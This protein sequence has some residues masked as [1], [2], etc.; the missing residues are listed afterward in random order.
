MVHHIVGTDVHLV[1]IV[2]HQRS[3]GPADAQE[4]SAGFLREV[5]G[6]FRTADLLAFDL[7][8]VARE[9]VLPLRQAR[10]GTACDQK[11]GE[12]REYEVFAV[13]CHKINTFPLLIDKNNI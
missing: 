3:A 2:D 1:V 8:L 9:A 7:D 10:R 13:H 6:E 4:R 11:A 12:D 5:R